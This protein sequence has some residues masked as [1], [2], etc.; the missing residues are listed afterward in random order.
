MK[1]LR[2]RIAAAYKDAGET[3]IQYLAWRLLW[4]KANPTLPYGIERY[5]NLRRANYRSV[6]KQAG[7]LRKIRDTLYCQCGLLAVEVTDD[8]DYPY[9]R[10][11]LVTG[12]VLI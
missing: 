6:A 2:T 8:G 11:N 1:Y 9:I 12:S 3:D 10:E 5:N 7:N 4:R